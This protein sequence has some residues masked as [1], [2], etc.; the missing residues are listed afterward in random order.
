MSLLPFAGCGYRPSTPFPLS[1]KALSPSH[2]IRVTKIAGDDEGKLA[3]ALIREIGFSGILSYSEEGDLTLSAT[4]IRNET[5]HIG[6]RYDRDAKTGAR[7]NRLVPDEGRQ[8][9][10]IRFSLLSTETGERV[11]GPFETEGRSHFDFIDANSPQDASFFDGR[12][13]RGSTLSFSMG[14][15]DSREGARENNLSYLYQKIA[16]EMVRGMEHLSR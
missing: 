12:G 15:L 7:I 4:I 3:E 9:V 14:Q 16:Y 10:T 6:W 5:T 1:E 2:T 13:V 8:S 11:Y